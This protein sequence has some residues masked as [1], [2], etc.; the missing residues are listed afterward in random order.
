[1]QTK[2]NADD[3][4]WIWEGAAG[5]HDFKVRIS[6][7]VVVSLLRLYVCFAD[8]NATSLLRDLNEI[9]SL[10]ACETRVYQYI[11]CTIPPSI[12]VRR[13]DSGDLPRGT[14][15]TLHLKPDAEE[16]A[17]PERISGAWA[18]LKG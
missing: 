1:M 13:D 6:V 2:S 5:A 8:C 17:D 7:G 9:N 10:L 14:R 4:A 16:F 15:I 12:Q 11:T 3:G 18:G